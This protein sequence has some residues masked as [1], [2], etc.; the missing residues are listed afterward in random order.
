MMNEGVNEM[1]TDLSM[2]FENNGGPISP[3]QRKVDPW[4]GTL[5]ENYVFLNN[6][7]KGSFGE[8]VVSAYFEKL[9]GIRVNPREN[10]GHDCIIGNEKVE[11]KF[12]LAQ[13]LPNN[14][15]ATKHNQFMLNHVSVGKDWDRLVFFGINMNNENVHFW[16]TKEDFTNRY[17]ELELFSA[18]QGG[19]KLD[20]D[21][22][23]CSKI[24]RTP[25]SRSRYFLVDQDWVYPMESW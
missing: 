23:M 15:N 20:N 2:L 1:S 17:R 5:Y 24:A 4:V 10:A 18:Q 16:F 7:Q 21:D 25:R 8:E 11:I 12:S 13:Q 22:W 6:N 9:L 14:G 3:I 19:D